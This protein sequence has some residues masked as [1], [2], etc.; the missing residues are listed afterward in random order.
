MRR[1]TNL[2]LVVGLTATAA[3]SYQRPKYA[4][5]KTKEVIERMIEAHGGLEKWRK[6]PAISFNAHL[7]VNF[8]GNNWVPFW[9]EATV[10]TATRRAYAKLPN[11]DGTHGS[12]AFDGKKAWSAGNLQGI[13]RAP[14]RFTA[15]R[16]FYLFNIPWLTQ[17]AG[18]NLGE[19]GKGK[20]SMLEDSKEYFTVKMTF[21]PGTGDTPKDHYVLY[22]DPGTYR[23][24]ASEH[25]MTF[26][27]MMQ[28]DAAT[29]P[30]SIFVWEET[31]NVDG[32]IVPA[33]YTV[34]WKADNSIAVKDGAISNWSFSKPFDESR[35]IM[36]PDGE[37]DESSPV[38]M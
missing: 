10:E 19:P 34:Y 9:E 28:G 11:A 3:K 13:A 20:L 8:G 37:P 2:L 14:A 17:D 31:A 7:K 27:S 4:S 15:W 12:V 22:I 21:D 29:S 5:A 26:A 33:K 25:V 6:A 36:P 23:L 1:I 18:V 32:L 16:N 38:K 24:K 30:P 35:L